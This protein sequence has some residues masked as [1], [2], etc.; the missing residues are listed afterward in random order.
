MFPSISGATQQYLADIGRTET[1]LQK[2]TSDVTSGI[3]VNQ[4]SDN[5]SAVSEILQVQASI[6]RNQQIQNNLGNVT[7]EVNTADSALQTA[8]QALTT[9]LTLA[10]Q[11]ATSTSTAA[12]RATLAQQVAGIQQTMVGVAQTTLNGRYIFSGDQ[13]SQAPYQLDSTQPEGVLQL[14]AGTSTRTI[15]SID[16]TSFAVAL[17]AQQIFDSRN[18]DGTPASGNVFAALQNLE[19][20]LTNNDTAGIT[21][22]I[23]SLQSAGTYLNN[24]LAFYGQVEN[25]VQGATDLA[26]KFQTQQT[27]ELSNLRDTDIPT[28]AAE[29]TQLQTQQ[30]ASMSVEANIE[31]QKNLF[32]Y[33]A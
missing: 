13:D 33:L 11:G 12:S 5:P 7:A 21:S 8:V 20:A 15:Q 27:V 4:A 30:Q 1:Q 14:A 16:G 28:A 24:Q 9:A 25:R 2:T 23:G 17:T 31:Q 26:Q 3:S 29:L 22:S 6:S 32:S 19:T 10:S 18:P